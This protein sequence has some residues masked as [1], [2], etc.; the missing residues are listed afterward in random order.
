MPVGVLALHGQLPGAAC[1][2]SSARGARVGYIQTAGGA[3]PGQ[4][5]DVV[6]ELLDR[7]LLVDHVTVAPCFGG[8]HEAITV[9]GAL[10]AGAGA[11]LGCALVGP[12]PGILGSASVLGHG[13][14]AALARSCRAGGRLSRGDRAAAVGGRPESAIAAS[15][16]TR[17]TVLELLLRPV[18]WRCRP[19][20][21]GA[22]PRCE[23]RSEAGG[24]EAVKVEVD[25]LLAAYATAACRPRRWAARSTR[26]GTSSAPALA[27]GA[28]LRTNGRRNRDELRARRRE[29]GLEGH[30]GTVGSSSSA[31]TMARSSSARSSSIPGAVVVVP[32]DGERIW[33]VRQPREAVGEQGCSSCRPAS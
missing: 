15:A 1:D 13:G 9:E 5:S 32:F 31:T 27:G 8:R 2:R 12:G 4:L 33:L 21:R 7:E 20:T 16:I 14:L 18:G 10:D 19:R 22:R 28:A 26:T 29:G 24:H 23:R 11:G 3:L 30:I 25:E 17:A 6:A